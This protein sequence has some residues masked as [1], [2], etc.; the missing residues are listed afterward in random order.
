VSARNASLL[1]GVRCA[2]CKSFDKT[3]SLDLVGNY[4]R[5]MEI[6]RCGGCGEPCANRLCDGFQ[7]ERFEDGARG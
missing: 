3:V 6:W 5:T 7:S 2:C 1:V 4:R